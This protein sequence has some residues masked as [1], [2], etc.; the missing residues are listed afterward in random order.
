MSR[1]C[2]RLGTLLAALLIIATAAVAQVRIDTRQL[3][4]PLAPSGK[5]ATVQVTANL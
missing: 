5:D 4:V 2:F 1:S 3:F